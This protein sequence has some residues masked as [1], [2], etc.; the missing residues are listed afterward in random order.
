[1]YVCMLTCVYVGQ[2]R[3]SLL[4]NVF[5]K[6]LTKPRRAQ[7]RCTAAVSQSRNTILPNQDFL[8]TFRVPVL[9]SA[10]ALSM[11]MSAWFEDAEHIHHMHCSFRVPV[12]S[13]STN[14]IP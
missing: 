8:Y 7:Q 13:A 14:Q 5:G 12:D 4:L 9:L 1:M 10:Q 6:A 3:F 11:Q 2:H